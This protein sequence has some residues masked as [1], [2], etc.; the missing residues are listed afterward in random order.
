MP[1]VPTYSQPQVQEAAVSNAKFTDQAPLEAFG[2]GK[3][4]ADVS[5]GFDDVTKEAMQIARSEKIK[6][7]QVVVLDADQKLS[8]AETQLLYDP[9]QG[10]LNKRGKDAFGLPDQV[11]QSYQST[12]NSI[13]DGMTED[14]RMSFM[15]MA[16][17]RANDLNRKVQ[18]HVSGE[19]TKY[20]ATVTDGYISSE[21]DAA[22]QNYQDPDRVDLSIERQR[23]ALIDHANRNG[24]PSEW[25]QNQVEQATSSTRME[26][27]NRML[28]NEQDMA[29][30]K[31]YEANKA[32]FTGKDATT[33]EKSL[34]EGTLRGE[35]QRTSDQI[36]GSTHSMGEALE[37]ARKI[38]DPKV[39]DATTDRIKDYFS[40]QKAAK[41]EQE[42]NDFKQA[43]DIIEQS[44]GDRTKVPPDLWNRL[45][46]QAHNAIDARAKQLKGGI[47]PTTDWAQYYN[48]KSIASVP[49]TRNKFLQ[50]NLLSVRPTLA[51]P[52][53]KEL[54][55]LQ[56]SLRQGDDKADKLLDG[57]RSDSQIVQ[58]TLTNAGIKH[59]DPRATVFRRQVDDQVTAQQERS[60]KKVTSQEFQ[61]IVD[62]QFVKTVNHSW[63]PSF[64]SSP[65]RVYEVPPGQKIEVDPT[66]IPRSERQKIEQALMRRGIQ[67]TDDRVLDL[68]TR[69]INGR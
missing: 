5:Q 61:S 10:A 57:F 49:E 36:I 9:Q 21:R 51:D 15:R 8:Q 52:E 30:K 4:L 64:L 54:V 59:D 18:A 56:S 7:D 65:T 45:T 62:N 69:K 66:D 38:E 24:L 63:I 42:D 3:P 14:Q 29:A 48:L 33:L 67:P 1:V 12:V 41:N 2:G 17:S 23:A 32:D 20:D 27:I 25:V 50:M 53:F 22:A 58:D 28:A 44:G 6:Q 47:E 13:A 43:S 55:H 35:S 40:Q 46:L 11:T 31:Y 19:M 37:Q 26:V 34:E 60:G 68:Y 39:R 16:V